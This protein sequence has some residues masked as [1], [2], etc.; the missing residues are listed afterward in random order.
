MARE[1]IRAIEVNK[2]KQDPLPPPPS[3]VLPVTRVALFSPL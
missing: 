3:E 1:G 2:M